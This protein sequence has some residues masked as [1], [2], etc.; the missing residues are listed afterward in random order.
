M[1]LAH[2]TFVLLIKYKLMCFL[3]GFVLFQ[4]VLNLFV[5][6]PDVF[7]DSTQISTWYQEPLLVRGIHWKQNFRPVQDKY[8]R[9]LLTAF[10]DSFSAPAELLPQT[11]VL[12]Q[13]ENLP[14]ALPSILL[15]YWPTQVW[16]NRLV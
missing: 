14:H 7:C 6:F 8:V 16:H 13:R 1:I 5:F 3:V 4:K 15:H 9:T 12:S 2:Y 11:F 10:Q